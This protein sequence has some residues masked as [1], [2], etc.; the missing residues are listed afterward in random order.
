MGQMAQAVRIE[1]H[2]TT[3]QRIVSLVTFY[4][5]KLLIPPR[6]NIDVVVLCPEQIDDFY[7]NEGIQA[8][9]AWQP[10]EYANYRMRVRCDIEPASLNWIIM[11]ELLEAITAPY[12]TFTQQFIEKVE[13]R[14]K[15]NAELLMEQHRS[16][17]DEQIEW[18]L[19]IIAGD[20]RPPVTGI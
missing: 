13:K 10:L 2:E 1:S 5:K 14:A 3:H 4:R 17:R 16:I 9:I 18:L 19:S 6:W 15:A 7:E 11:H 12:A 8:S 20:K